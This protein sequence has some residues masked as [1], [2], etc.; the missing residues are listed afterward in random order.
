MA[1]HIRFSLDSFLT[2]DSCV[3]EGEEP[4][5]FFCLLFPLVALVAS[6]HTS[7]NVVASP[8]WSRDS[9]VGSSTPPTSACVDSPAM[10]QNSGA[11]TG[12][13]LSAGAEITSST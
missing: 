2:L 5:R 4:L 8:F 13:L 12:G 7:A 10:S 6:F 1:A 11:S 9:L 3:F